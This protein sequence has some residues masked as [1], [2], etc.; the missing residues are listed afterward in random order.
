[1]KT[2]LNHESLLTPH[3]LFPTAPLLIPSS[4][5]A[6]LPPLFT[7]LNDIDPAS[8]RRETRYCRVALIGD[9]LLQLHL[10]GRM[11]HVLLPP[12]ARRSSSL[13]ET[14][15]GGST[16]PG[17]GAGVD[18]VGRNGRL[19]NRGVRTSTSRG[20]HTLERP[21]ASMRGFGE[22]LVLTGVCLGLSGWVRGRV[23][24]HIDG[25]AECRQK[26]KSMGSEEI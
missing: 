22:L 23:R 9:A 19:D 5:L 4:R 1:M 20:L 3:L 21:M 17:T 14:M 26:K 24:D 11:N 12:A 10:L 25:L 2:S 6:T 18:G 13:R 7:H 8:Q 16:E 15:S